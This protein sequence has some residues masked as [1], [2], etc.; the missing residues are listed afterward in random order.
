MNKR[1]LIL[2][3]L[4]K[5]LMEGKGADDWRQKFGFIELCLLFLQSCDQGV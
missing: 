4:E 2:E 3:T 1:N 5:E